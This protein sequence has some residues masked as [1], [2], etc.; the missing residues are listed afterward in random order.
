MGD[1]KWKPANKDTVVSELTFTLEGT[2]EGK[3]YE[4][5]VAAENKAG[6]GPFS[7]PSEPR[8]YG[9]TFILLCVSVSLHVLLTILSCVYM[10]IN[11]FSV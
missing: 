1:V 10:V 8:K 6:V 5:R 3:D 11:T 2:S 9:K 7:P 4:F